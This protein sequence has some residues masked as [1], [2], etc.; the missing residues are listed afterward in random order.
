MRDEIRQ[1]NARQYHGA[2]KT[3]HDTINIHDDT[4]HA[5]PKDQ[6]LDVDD[7]SRSMPSILKINFS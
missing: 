4:P 6:C 2:G 5:K 3:K 1:G 7:F